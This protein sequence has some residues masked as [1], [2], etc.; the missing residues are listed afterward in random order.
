MGREDSSP[1]WTPPA[2]QA[3]RGLLDPP[4]QNPP[5]HPEPLCTMPSRPHVRASL[6][7]GFR[8]QATAVVKKWLLVLLCWLGTL[9]HAK[10]GFKG[11]TKQL[12]LAKRENK[13]KAKIPKQDLKATEVKTMYFSTVWNETTATIFFFFFFSF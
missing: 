10:Q 4:E 7:A 5:R 3:R 1:Q 11:F 9:M 13:Q 12:I 8:N 6:Y 2:W